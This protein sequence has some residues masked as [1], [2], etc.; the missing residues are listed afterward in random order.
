MRVHIFGQPGGCSI[1]SDPFALNPKQRGDEWD[2]TWVGLSLVVRPDVTAVVLGGGSFAS[3]QIEGRCGDHGPL[4]QLRRS[5]RT[6]PRVRSSGPVIEDVQLD[7]PT[8][9]AGAGVGLLDGEARGVRHGLPLERGRAAHRADD[10]EHDGLPQLRRVPD[11]EG[12]EACQRHHEPADG[13][14]VTARDHAARSRRRW[15]AG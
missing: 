13:E 5:S 2:R 15:R 4:P 11:Q 3:A 9:G 10:G 8:V 7:G 1:L 12:D 6:A 14:G